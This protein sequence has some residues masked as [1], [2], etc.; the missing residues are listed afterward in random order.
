MGRVSARPYTE[1]SMRFY[2]PDNMR[3]YYQN[4]H[5]IKANILDAHPEQANYH[6]A[7]RH[8]RLGEYGVHEMTEEK[9][10]PG[11]TRS[12]KDCKKC[13]QTIKSEGRRCLVHV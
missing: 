10:K 2:I 7:L 4:P 9:L 3:Q 11:K 13:I 6:T 5:L 8:L 12:G 1:V